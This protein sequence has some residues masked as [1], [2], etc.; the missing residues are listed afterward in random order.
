MCQLHTL[1]QILTATLRDTSPYDEKKFRV[2]ES[3]LKA[4]QPLGTRTR[5]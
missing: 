5:I 2:V 3:L 1:S 4:T